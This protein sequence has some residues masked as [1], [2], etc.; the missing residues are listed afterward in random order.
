MKKVNKFLVVLCVLA[1]A[2]SLTACGKA[3][4]SI[5]YDES[6]VTSYTDQIIKAVSAVTLKDLEAQETSIEEDVYEFW[7][8]A[9]TSWEK[10]NVDLE[11]IKSIDD[12]EITS[13]EKDITVIAKITGNSGAKAEI[14]IIFD[15]RYN[16]TSCTTNVQ[17]S[18][19]EL[20]TNAALNTLL[21]MGTVFAVLIFICF[22][23]SLFKLIGVV[24]KKMKE[25]NTPKESAAAT[26]ADK[27]VA[28]IIEN[29][30]MADDY[31]IIAVISAAIAAYEESQGN[32]GDG[33]VVRSIKKRY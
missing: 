16:P 14:E 2:L 4:N 22:I 31:E 18:F 24:E 30:E 9:V 19:G 12:E 32:S 15:K 8:A 3:D 28:Q 25:K 21:G 17:K 6:V 27:A 10:A 29:E 11:G 26:A 20:M 7:L 13:S 23:I 5:K 33:Y 1:M